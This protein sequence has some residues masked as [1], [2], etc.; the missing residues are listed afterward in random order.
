MK[1][2]K[3]LALILVVTTSLY[4]KEFIVNCNESNVRFSLVY[5]KEKAINGIFKDFD[6]LII[7]DAE[8]KIESIKGFIDISSV[9][10]QNSFLNELIVSEKILNAK[11]YSEMELYST[12]I[13]D[14][15][16]YADLLIN[17]AKRNVE[18]QLVNNGILLDK[19]Y[20][21]LS[22]TIFKDSFDLYWDV[23]SDLGSSVTSNEIKIEINI[24]ADLKSEINFFYE[25]EKKT[26]KRKK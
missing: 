10:T 22:T 12:K 14:S 24:V 20:F 4:A 3:S 8:N 25:K 15:K 21:T 9:E 23:L 6:G 11:K 16:V 19:L 18:F 26:K 17:G 13:E 2:I 7:Y 5:Q 1:L